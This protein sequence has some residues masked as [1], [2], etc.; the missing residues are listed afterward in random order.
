[1]ETNNSSKS[2]FLN[3]PSIYF[4]IAAIYCFMILNFVGMPSWRHIDDYGPLLK[5]YNA[6]SINEFIKLFSWWGW[7]SY[8]PIWQYFTFSSY[9]FKPFGLDTVR[10]ICFFYGS[11]SLVFSSFL[12]FSICTCIKNI[13]LQN[14]YKLQNNY[15]LEILSIL[16]NFL[17]PEIILHSNSNM[18]YNLGTITLQLAV[19]FLFSIREDKFLSNNIRLK[20]SNYFLIKR[21][22]LIIALIFSFLL[23]FQSIILILALAITIVFFSNKNKFKFNLKFIKIKFIIIYFYS[24]LKDSNKNKLKLYLIICLSFFISTYIFKLSLMIFYFKF[25]PGSWA[26]GINNIYDLSLFDN[27]LLK[28]GLIFFRNTISIIGQS[29]NPSRNFQTIISIVLSLIFVKSIFF[30]RKEYNFG[31]VFQIF[32][33][34]IIL[35]TIFFTLTG[36]FIYSPTRH[37]IFI[38]PLIWIPIILLIDKI[39]INLG[40]K[41]INKFFILFIVLIFSLSAYNS[42]KEISYTKPDKEKLISLI[43]DADCYLPNSYE[44][45]SNLSMQGSKEYKLLSER[46]CSFDNIKSI[47]NKKFFIYSHREPL[48]LTEKQVYYINNKNKIYLSGNLDINVI[49]KFEKINQIDLEM[50]NKIR[51]GGSNIF[52]YLIEININ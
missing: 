6:E 48:T 25:E 28:N 37:T 11:I 49:K 3:K 38:Y 47:N 9:I 45:F 14:N 42:V 34:F 50:N 36:S 21:E 33:F 22:I 51:N 4:W 7:G 10:Y 52:A 26:K 24:L 15:T 18:P 31:K 2:L 23:T 40:N 8:P 43:K 12:T 29:I 39:F 20:E 32:S 41:K 30:I 35:L 16:F 17:N 44:P 46:K 19:L 5:L 13:N 27:G 1:M